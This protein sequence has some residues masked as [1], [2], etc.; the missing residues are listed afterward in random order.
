MTLISPQITNWI[1]FECELPLLIIGKVT[2]R[3]KLQHDRESMRSTFL[4]Y[5]SKRKKNSV[6]R[7]EK[8]FGCV[9]L[10]LFVRKFL[11]FI[12]VEATTNSNR[13]NSQ[14]GIQKKAVNT[15]SGG[16]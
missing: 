16:N 11:A 12:R 9:Y 1:L 4:Q 7:T 6:Q 13:L 8:L 10:L 2:R 14:A 3:T 15:A 5:S